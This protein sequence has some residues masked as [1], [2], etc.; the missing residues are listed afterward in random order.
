MVAYLVLDMTPT[1]EQPRG[2]TTSLLAKVLFVRG[3]F[4]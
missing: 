3:N 1:Q 4:V 2:H